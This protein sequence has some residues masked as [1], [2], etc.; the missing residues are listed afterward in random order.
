MSSGNKYHR[1]VHDLEDNSSVAT[2]DVYSVLV[3]FNVTCPARQHAIKKLLC[4][5]LR[6]K[7]DCL[8]DLIESKDAVERAVQ[9]QHVEVQEKF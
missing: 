9:L 7:G 1:Q 5:G 8:Q 2:V 4:A 3:A 6:G